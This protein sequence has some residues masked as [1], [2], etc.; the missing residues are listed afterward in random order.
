MPNQ[1]FTNNSESTLAS[2][3]TA[4]AVTI[5]VPAGEGALFSSPVNGDFQM[6]T[7]SDGT[8]TEVIKL[9]ARAADSLTVVRAQEGTSG[10]A[11]SATDTV[12]ARLTKGTLEKLFQNTATQKLVKN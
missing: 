6:I 1:L 12:D 3:I 8:N 5:T 2:G 11:F 10:F 9:T 7:L 4:V